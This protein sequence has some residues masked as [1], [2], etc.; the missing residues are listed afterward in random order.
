MRP[1]CVA[2]GQQKENDRC[3][4]EWIVDGYENETGRP[5]RYRCKRV[6]L[7]TG[8]TDLSNRL[9]IPDESSHADWITHDLNDLESMLDRLIDQDQY[10]GT[11]TFCT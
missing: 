10:H 9:G 3:G 8:T 5:F 7:A 2:N 1:V 4:H 6:V 11:A